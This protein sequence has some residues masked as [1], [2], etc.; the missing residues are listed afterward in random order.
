MLFRWLNAK[1]PFD[2]SALLGSDN[3]CRG[4]F[5]NFHQH[6]RKGNRAL[7]HYI[8]RLLTD[9]NKLRVPSNPIQTELLTTDILNDLD[10]TNIHLTRLGHSSILLKIA[11]EFWLI[12][13]VFSER[14]SPF[15]FIGPKR[16]HPPPITIDQLPVLKGVIISHNHYD[17]LDKQSI[18]QLIEKTSH[19]YVPLG[20]DGD[21]VNW[22]VNTNSI[23]TFDW[24]QSAK[25]GDTCLRFTPAHHY[26]GRGPDD[27]CST[28]WGSW[29]IEHHKQSIFFSGDSG[30]FN[31]FKEI[32]ERYGPF[33]IC[34]METGAYDRQWPS[35]HMQPEQSWQAFLD[36]N[37]QVM[38]PIHN[39]TF[40]LAFHAWDHPLV[41]ITKLAKSHSKKLLIPKFGQIVTVGKNIKQSLWWQ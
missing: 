40:N 10:N 22:G 5:Q 31:G 15:S 28:L 1:A 37:S 36:T 33:D 20:V 32:G 27:N 26:S 13:P 8:K 14:A 21:L 29:V 11:G 7:L 39:S 41:S 34:L 4:K 23:S 18:K 6:Q 16:F 17:H 30:Y 38:L 2:Q 3:F 25:I 35:V 12:D 9:N 19:F 24:W